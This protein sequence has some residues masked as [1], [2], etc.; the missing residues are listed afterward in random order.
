M[1]RTI[2][3]IALFVPALC[4]AGNTTAPAMKTEHAKTSHY[5]KAT[6]AKEIQLSGVTEE[7]RQAVESLAKEAGA[8]KASLDIATGMLKLHGKKFN[9]AKFKAELVKVPG[10]TQVETAKK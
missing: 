1:K 4:F 10:V 8:E 7:N 9:D 3:G 2:I 5:A 6:M